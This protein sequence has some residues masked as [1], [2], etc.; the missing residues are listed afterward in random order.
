MIALQIVGSDRPALVDDEFAD[1]AR[2]RWR[3]HRKGHVYREGDRPIKLV[4][5]IFG[6][7][8]PAGWVVAHANRDRLDCRRDNLQ[9]ITL[10]RHL[11]QPRV[12][13]RGSSLATA[14]VCTPPPQLDLWELPN[15]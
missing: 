15:V 6:A 8:P 10:S 3:L 2:Y 9:L 1:L 12:P 5:T 4:H 7:K 13:I 11:K 14:N